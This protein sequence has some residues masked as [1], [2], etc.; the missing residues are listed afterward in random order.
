MTDTEAPIFPPG[1]YGRR[2]QR[3]RTARWVPAALVTVVVA[4]MLAVAIMLF[5]RYG[6]P[7]YQPALSGYGSVTDHAITVTFQVTKRDPGPAVCLA[8]AKDRT[9]GEVGRLEVAVPEGSRVTVTATVPTTA[10]ATG[11]K[12]EG[13]RAR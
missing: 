7:V 10:Q 8:V 9:M 11:V 5:Q 6:N 12:I 3:R 13:C 4:G 2:R 1:R